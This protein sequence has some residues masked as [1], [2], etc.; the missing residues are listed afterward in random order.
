MNTKRFSLIGKNVYGALSAYEQIYNEKQKQTKQT[1][2]DLFLKRRTPPQ[3]EPQ[4]GPG[5]GIP[6]EGSVVIGDEG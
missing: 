5:G 3:A 1:T 2:M 6:E 4:A